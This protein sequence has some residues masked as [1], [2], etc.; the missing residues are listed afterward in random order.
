[1]KRIVLIIVIVLV[2]TGAGWWYYQNY[3]LNQV[4]QIQTYED[5]VAAGYQVLESYP[6]KCLTP[7][8][9]TIVDEV[10]LGEAPMTPN[11]LARLDGAFT[12]DTETSTLLWEGKKDLIP[13]Y[14]D[15][16]TV[17]LASSSLEIDSG[18]I[19]SLALTFDLNSISALETG[20]GDGQSN[21]AN[22]LKSDD[23]FDVDKYPTALFTL[24]S[25]VVGEKVGDYLW[26]GNLTIKETTRP[27]EVPVTVSNRNGVLAMT[28]EVLVDRTLF[29][30]RYG[31]AGTADDLGN[32]VIANE[33]RLIFNLVAKPL[34]LPPSP[35]MEPKA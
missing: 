20:R 7:D 26:R 15:R 17:D 10:A 35:A 34:P 8:G 1:M 19:K 27:I 24:T 28:G 11:P 22:H 29:G 6:P 3:R 33:F 5:C 23:F 9:R 31:A 12:F 14:V 30:L 32:N 18:Q 2:L 25:A 21:L 13:G 16:G 4:S